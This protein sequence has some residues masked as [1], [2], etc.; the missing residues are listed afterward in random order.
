[1]CAARPTDARSSLIAI[2]AL[3]FIASLG[4]GV[5]WSGISF[6]AKHDFDYTA[7]QNFMLYIATAVAYVGGAFASGP[8]S[9]ALS[10]WLSPRGL[11]ATIMIAQ[12]TLCLL[13]LVNGLPWGVFA[14]GDW[15]LWVVASSVSV[16]A[17]L[18]WPIIESYLTAGR[19]GREMRSAIG[20]WNITWTSAVAIALVAMAPLVDEQRAVLAIVALAPLNAISLLA[21]PWF[22]RAPGAHDEVMWRASITAEYPLLLRSVR[23]LLPASYLLIGALSPLMPYRLVEVGAEPLVQTPAT[24]V[25]MVARVVAIS[26]MWRVAFWHGR[27]GTLLLAGSVMTGG[28][29]VV[30]ASP[31]LGMMLA[32]LAAFGAAQGIVYYAALYYAMSVGAAAVDAGG[33]HEGLIGV[34]YGAGAAAALIGTRGS[35]AVGATPATGIVTVV[36]ALLASSATL[37]VWPYLA[38]RRLR[39]R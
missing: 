14:A 4:T 16:L 36:G 35:D 38:A 20:W 17:A 11:L 39:A 26:V 9:R 5:L 3:T 31:N 24:A 8:L 6:I 13:P 25:W 30:V 7:E 18:L 34:G 32:G 23:V 10:R 27:W 22:T 15:A 37:A 33:V 29:A 2:L 21:L 12:T 19:H 1:M 28:F